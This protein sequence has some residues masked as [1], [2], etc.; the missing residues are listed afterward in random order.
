MSLSVLDVFVLSMLD[1]GAKSAYD[2]RRRAGISLGASTPSLRR[3][4]KNKLVTL[5]KDRSPTN[6]RRN[7]VELTAAGR[8][9]ARKGWKSWL[10][11]NSGVTDLDS[12][13]RIADMASQYG[14][15]PYRIKKFLKSAGETK[16]LMAD[17]AKG[18]ARALPHSGK[19]IYGKM[20]SRCDENRLRAEA[21]ALFQ[22][23]SDIK[24]PQ[25]VARGQQW[26][27]PPS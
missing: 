10:V 22:I 19:L 25:G 16:L 24:R 8:E 17:S 1:R 4:V 6:H 7:S 15:D 21:D 3:L 11:D 9:Q 26:L 12:L 20:R 18:T 5:E 13:L 23:A 14:A 2:L 27:I